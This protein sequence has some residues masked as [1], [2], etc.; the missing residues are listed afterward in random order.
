MNNYVI[1]CLANIGVDIECDDE[2][3]FD[4][5]LFLNDSMT[6]ISFIIELESVLDCEIPFEMIQIENMASVNGFCLMLEDLACSEKTNQCAM[7]FR[8]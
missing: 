2:K 7:S 8:F 1:E 4:L 6:L 3:D 5:R